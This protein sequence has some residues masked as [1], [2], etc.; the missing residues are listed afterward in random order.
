MAIINVNAGDDLQAAINAAVA[1]DRIVIE[2]G[3]TF[4]GTFTLPVKAGSA[5]ITLESSALASLPAGVRVSPASA[6]NMPKLTSGSGQVSYAI[7]IAEGAHH[8]KLLGLE[9]APLNINSGDTLVETAPSGMTPTDGRVVPYNITIDRCYI[10]GIDGSSINTVGISLNS[11]DT[12][13]TNCYISDFAGHYRTDSQ[14]IFAGNSPGNLT[15]I[16][17][18]LSA[19]SENIQFGYGSG[20]GYTPDG[21]TMKRNLVSKRDDRKTV[22]KNIKNLLE[23]KGGTN[24]L[25]EG[26]TFENCWGPHS[27]I[28]AGQNGN[29]IVFTPYDN[30][31]NNIQFVN[32]VVRFAGS[33]V[34]I[35]SEKKSTEAHHITIRN[36]LFAHITNSGFYGEGVFIKIGGAHDI[37]ADHNTVIHDGTIVSAFG[38]DP[39]SPNGWR[40]IPGFVFTN[41]IANHNAYGIFS[42]AGFGNLTIAGFFPGSTWQRNIIWACW[43]GA[44]QYPA[45]NFYPATREV[46]GFVNY[47]TGYYN[48]APGTAYKNQATDNKDPGVDFD[49]LNAALAGT[50]P[51]PTVTTIVVSPTSASVQAGQTRQFTAEAFD[52]NGAPMTG[53]TFAWSSSDPTK[54][55]INGS[56]LVTAVAAG[57]TQITAAASGVTSTPRTVTV[58]PVPAPTVHHVEVAPTSALLDP[59]ATVAFSAVAYDAANNPLPGK[60]FTWS[61][62]APSVATISSTGVLQGLAAGT[63]QV[64]ATCEGV[65]SAPRT[66]TVAQLPQP[67][68]QLVTPASGESFGPA[69]T[70]RC[71]ANA[72]APT[73]QVTRVEFYADDVLQGTPVTSPPYSKEIGPLAVGRRELKAVAYDS[74]GNVVTSN[75]ERVN[76]LATPIVFEATSGGTLGRSRVR[77]VQVPPEVAAYFGIDATIDT[78][79]AGDG[80]PLQFAVSLMLFYYLAKHL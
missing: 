46:V 45:D 37:T 75:K 68:V 31:V 23:F 61:S 25:I 56:G 24:A 58:T 7:R 41:N 4:Q 48:L 40:Q 54:A 5:Y 21:I 30:H 67:T 1:G 6:A 78:K 29:A 59:G 20:G 60:V 43:P 47:D 73:G 2:A 49:L 65:V 57:T 72:V 33:G 9:I 71:H 42:S 66:A 8:W 38:D 16:N 50:T 55:T 52:Q 26:N 13:I 11:R 3:A 64:R 79:R 80:D 74:L 76:I 27:T 77:S 22:W 18:Y 35:K 63:T 62:S 17:N 15:I 69:S 12:E 14:A 44:S 32:N 34:T 28:D 36:C 53:V 51:T 19:A 70:I 10:H 39:E